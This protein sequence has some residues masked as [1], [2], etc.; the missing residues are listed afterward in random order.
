MRAFISLVTFLIAIALNG[1]GPTLL[2]LQDALQLAAE[3]AYAVRTSSLEAEKA[4][5]Q[6]KEIVGLGLP[7]VNGAAGFSDFIDIPVQVSESF[8]GGDDLM[9]F[10]FGL[11]YSA[12]AGVQLDQL[13]FDGSYLVGLQASRAFKHNKE[14]E[15][16]QSIHD[17]K[18]AAAKAYYAVLVAREGVE[19]IEELIPV[20]EEN[21]R[22][23]KGLQENGFADRTD[24]DRQELGLSEVRN[25]LI[26]MENQEATAL[27]ML[28]FVLGLPIS[29]PLDLDNNLD[30]L[31]QDPDPRALAQS[32][33]E[34]G[35]HID[36][37]VAESLVVLQELNERNEKATALPKLYGFVSH[38]QNAYRREFDFFGSGQWYPTT[39]WGVNLQV[40]IFSGGSRHHKVQ[41]AH[42][43]Y[44]QVIVNQELVNEQL[45]LDFEQRRKNLLAEADRY[46]NEKRNL[47][48]ARK[49]FDNTNIKYREGL[50]TSFELTEERSQLLNTQNAYIQSLADL[51]F[52]RADLRDALGLF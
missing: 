39:L 44:D 1:Q 27:D 15:L 41:Q 51:L 17:A 12:N 13:I 28:H 34:P 3:Q 2:T 37:K 20:L 40:P 19:N 30:D 4:H 10:Q 32:A 8:F 22:Q 33:F 18:V 16:Q 42:I 24:V 21:L 43:T 29:T 6:L 14:Q 23:V 49:I 35:A 48:L 45:L 31:L 50:A 38:Q 25:Q 36:S 46:D 7:Q 52:A 5:H 9:T 26:F 47:E 11:R